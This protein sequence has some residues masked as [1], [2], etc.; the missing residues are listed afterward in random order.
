MS[1][2]FL[3]GSF[4]AHALS[5]NLMLNNAWTGLVIVKPNAKKIMHIR[6]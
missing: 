5:Q 4:V 6:S 3:Q 2:E 1:L